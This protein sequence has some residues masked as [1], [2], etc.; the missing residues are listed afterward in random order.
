MGARSIL[1]QHLMNQSLEIIYDPQSSRVEP[2]DENL[3]NEGSEVWGNRYASGLQVL[4]ESF[5][6]AKR[7]HYVVGCGSSGVTQLVAQLIA[8]NV[9]M[10]PNRLGLWEDDHV[11]VV[12]VK[13]NKQLL[14]FPSRWFGAF[15][16][17]IGY[18]LTS[19]PNL[20]LLSP[21]FLVLLVIPSVQFRPA[22]NSK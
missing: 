16:H 14:L 7:A 18:C 11:D 6:A 1:R 9:H 21:V 10:D 22:P 17:M 8:G 2:R 13:L 3:L 19:A 20:A 4:A 5:A 12:S 15:V